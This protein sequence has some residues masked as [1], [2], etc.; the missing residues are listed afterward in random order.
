LTRSPDDRLWISW[1]DREGPILSS[2]HSFFENLSLTLVLLLVLQRFGRRQWGYISELS[3]EDHTVSLHPVKTD[4]TLGK[5]EV[6]VNFYPEDK[7]HSAWTLLGRATNIIGANE[8][9]VGDTKATGDAQTKKSQIQGRF[10]GTP[11]EQGI[12]QTQG[13]NGRNDVGLGGNTTRP[14]RTGLTP[15]AVVKRKVVEAEEVQFHRDRDN[16]RRVYADTIKSHNLVLKIS[17]PETSRTEEWKIIEHAWTLAGGDEFIK[18]HIPDVKY[19]RDLDRYSTKHIRAFLGLQQEGGL[20]ARTL[21]LIVMNRLWPI[22]DLD[23][24]QFW[25]AIWQCVACA[26]FPFCLDPC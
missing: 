21:R 19:A 8:N 23:G 10:G 17:W 13:K 4:G 24:E 26:C 12:Q 6:F 9:E 22:Y 18:G 7:V 15:G 25:T 20:G 5:E 14:D 16:Y 2:D 3:A 1:I 11:Q